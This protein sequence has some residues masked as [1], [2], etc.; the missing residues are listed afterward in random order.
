MALSVSVTTS[1]SAINST[2]YIYFTNYNPL[3]GNTSL[4]DDLGY[5]FYYYLICSTT[6]SNAIITNTQSL[7]LKL[8]FLFI[9]PGGLG[10]KTMNGDDGQLSTYGGGE[11]QDL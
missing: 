8:N 11:E 1:T 2:E 7:S 3:T 4:L 10:G 5:K 6:S 9:G